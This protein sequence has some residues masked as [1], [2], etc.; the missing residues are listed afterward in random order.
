MISV[1]IYAQTVHPEQLSFIAAQL[2]VSVHLQD[3]QHAVK[4]L[5]NKINVLTYKVHTPFV[6]VRSKKL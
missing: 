3:N 4:N 1:L 6:F 2:H 5:L